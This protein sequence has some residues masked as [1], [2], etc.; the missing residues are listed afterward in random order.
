MAHRIADGIF[1]L[2]LKAND[3]IKTVFQRLIRIMGVGVEWTGN[4][5]IINN[6][7]ILAGR[8]R[9]MIFNF[10]NKKVSSSVMDI[11]INEAALI[12]VDDNGMLT[13]VLN[14]TLYIFGKWGAI[15]GL[16]VEKDYAQLNKLFQ[17]ILK[18][19]GIE[20][21]FQDNTIRFYKKEIR[22]TYEDTIQE[23]LD[24]TSK[25]EEAEE[26]IQE[27]YK[28]GLWHSMKWKKQKREYNW[29]KPGVKEEAERRLGHNFYPVSFLCPECGRNIAMVLYESDQEVLIDTEEGGVYLARAYTCGR[30]RI[31]T[32][33][34]PGRLLREGE[35]YE[36]DFQGDKE[37]YEDYLELIGDKGGG[38]ANFKLNEYEWQ[39][40]KR[41]QQAAESL[42][43]IARLMDQ[44]PEEELVQLRDRMEEGLF[45]RNEAMQYYNEVEDH[46]RVKQWE[47]ERERRNGRRDQE[48]KEADYPVGADNRISPKKKKRG[49][50]LKQLSQI[51]LSRFCK[52]GKPANARF[53]P[54]AGSRLQSLRSQAKAGDQEKE[55]DR[56]PL[57]K[58]ESENNQAR[59]HKSLSDRTREAERNTGTRAKPDKE[60]EA[61][62]QSN[63][64]RGQESTAA[65]ISRQQE[66]QHR[67]RSQSG[68]DSSGKNKQYSKADQRSGT[69]ESEAFDSY[70]RNQIPLGESQ[71]NLRVSKE[72][73]SA[74]DYEAEQ[75]HKKNVRLSE[76]SARINSDKNSDQTD[77][78]IIKNDSTPAETKDRN[79]E[80]QEEIGRLVKETDINDRNALYDLYHLLKS[81]KY[82]NGNVKDIL[83]ELYGQIE[84][85]DREE[86]NRI[87]PD[88]EKMDFQE[89]LKV[90]RR[91]QEGL[92][93]PQL[94][95]SMLKV[96]DKRLRAIKLDENSRLAE[97]LRRELE[98]VMGD[99]AR[100]YVC[101]IQKWNSGGQESR[102][103][104]II[105]RALN[106][107]G[108]KRGM[109]EYPVLVSDSSYFANGKEGFALTPDY[110]Y[111]RNLLDHGRI[112]VDEIE[113]LVTGNSFME[114]GIYLKRDGRKKCKL[115]NGVS[116]NEWDSFAEALGGFVEY[117]QEKPESRS[118]EYL[119][120][121]NH[122]VKCCYR[123]GFT[124]QGGNICP[125]CGSKTNR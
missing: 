58:E 100:L 55:S 64:Q 61:Y 24:W 26:E 66:E 125:N 70:E 118:I 113:E 38:M 116:K 8:L 29:S 13:D 45:P 28:L 57:N 93:L 96:L 82:S 122:K 76:D 107:Y 105:S 43:K 51:K 48:D 110:L 72:Q 75:R 11:T 123:C 71:R 81:G 49:T 34:V 111:Y 99:F 67:N 50:L 35:V 36:L 59:Q 14:M 30:C 4:F 89:A 92:Y 7:L 79:R 84:Q 124:Y 56:G 91:I 23:V 39:R 104:R 9:S 65:H 52:K 80:E 77:Y 60:P 15:T 37:A 17:H 31:F 33:A 47:K 20:P 86:L 97:K 120:H 88:P 117:L 27:E 2:Q 112:P 12:P 108:S 41:K 32:T 18:G 101:D 106:T 40:R 115:P 42:E 10:D 90:Y 69:E 73:E 78:R 94:K 114:R 68:P 44:M 103:E 98:A 19:A 63:L 119:A 25:E 22:I 6:N 62:G 16:K 46:I 121:E 102:E 1:M 5:I 21:S 85:L 87:C 95:G 3:Q 54:D 53:E 74:D 109:Y 83:D